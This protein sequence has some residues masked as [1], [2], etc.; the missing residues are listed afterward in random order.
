M[1]R[2]FLRYRTAIA[3]VLLALIA[4]G[5]TYGLAE[6]VFQ[7]AALNADE[8]SY[9]FQAY[10]FIDGKLRAHSHPISPRF[11]TR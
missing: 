9:L 6:Q 2:L 4:I 5:I 11:D 10:N 7:R 1:E 8:H 3:S